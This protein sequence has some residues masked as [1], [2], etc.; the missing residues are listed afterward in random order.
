MVGFELN[1]R[2]RGQRGKKYGKLPVI[3]REIKRA[4][5]P[6]DTTAIVK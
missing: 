2:N 6:T 1:E 5:D 3:K 4:D